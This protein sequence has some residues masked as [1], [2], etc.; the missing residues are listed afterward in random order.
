MKK[1]IFLSHLYFSQYTNISTLTYVFIF[2]ITDI[3][4]DKGIFVQNLLKKI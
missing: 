4:L 1:N 2:D 3:S